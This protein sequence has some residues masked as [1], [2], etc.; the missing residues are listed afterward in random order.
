[1]S[2][3]MRKKK[4]PFVSV[5]I[6]VY[7]VER[8]LSQCLDSVVSQTL[9]NIEIIIVNDGSTD[10]SLKIIN[11]YAEKDDRIIVVNHDENKGLFC[12]RITGVENANG[13]YVCFVDADDTVSIDWVRLLLK[14]ITESNADICIG[15]TVSVDEHKWKFYYNNTINFTKFKKPLIGEDLLGEFFNQEGSCFHWQTIWNKIYKKSLWDK[16]LPALKKQTHHLVMTEDILFSV[17]LFYFAQKTILRDID[18]YFYYRHHEASTGD[19]KSESKFIK[20]ITDIATVFS[21]LDS[22]FNSI[23]K[24]QK[25]IQ[26]LLRLKDKYYR[27]WCHAYINEFG[28]KNYIKHLMLD[29]FKKTKIED[30][31][32]YDFYAYQCTTEWNANYEN[33]KAMIYNSKCSVVSFDIF[34]TLILRP[35]WEPTDMFWLMAKPAEKIIGISNGAQFCKMRKNAENVARND[36]SKERPMR[37]DISISEIY[38]RFG[39]IYRLDKAKC[40]QLMLLELSLEKKYCQRRESGVELLEMCKALGKRIIL[41]SDMYLD[42]SFIKD[43]LSELGIEGYEE[44]FVSSEVGALKGTTNLYKYVC[45]YLDIQPGSLLHIGDNWNSD[46]VSAEKIGINTLFFAKPTEIFSKKIA[47]IPVGDCMMAFS[48]K[49][50]NIPRLEGALKEFSVRSVL[51]IVANKFFDRPNYSFQK[52]SD[53]NGDAFFIGYYILGSFVLGISKWI[54]DIALLCGYEKVIFLARD[55][56][57]I[58]DAFDKLCRKDERFSKIQSQYFYASRKALMPYSMTGKTDF[59]GIANY[60]NIYCHSPESINHL[61]QDVLL[62]LTDER[63]REYKNRGIDWE[64]RFNGIDEFYNYIN[65]L[66]EISYDER[67]YN[68]K[69]ES[70][71]QYYKENFEGNVAVFDVGY[72][73]KLPQIINRLCEKEVDAF[74]VHDSV[75]AS[76]IAIENGFKIHNYLDFTPAVSGVVM[77]YFLSSLEGSC[78]GYKSENNHVLPVIEKVNHCYDKEIAIITMQQGCASFIEDIITVFGDCLEQFNFRNM[79]IASPMLYYLAKSKEFDTYM[80]D[81]VELEDELFGRQTAIPFLQIYNYYL[82]KNNQVDE[83]GVSLENVRIIEK[84]TPPKQAS[85]LQKAIYWFLFDRKE[86]KIKY[87]SWLYQRKKK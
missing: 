39:E 55:G 54:Q 73:G 28:D 3:N 15:N 40:Q 11:D 81:Y 79:E 21:F 62:P 82:Q 46:I 32:N 64:K 10:G 66:V 7:N 33:I 9:E 25:W 35:F 78:I 16:A 63:K 31:Y 44:I 1:M 8:Y 71:R 48:D 27:V 19:H 60:V 67:F 53:F 37:E 47:N 50:A 45:N 5:I 20:N 58:Q 12:A 84:F 14:N 36:A 2:E 38:D 76:E 83:N 22:F 87:K 85:R 30:V 57:L 42:K 23:E 86:F 70:V 72:S 52:E 29:M 6:P 24:G 26:P 43:L 51:A 4:T 68:D 34:D 18:C 41:T 49:N 61:M 80:F 65:A 69:K 74:F 13:D 77:E 17:V 56:Y 59:Y 75:G